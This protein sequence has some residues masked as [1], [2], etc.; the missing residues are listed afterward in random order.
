MS[1]RRVPVP[2]GRGFCGGEAVPPA[3]QPLPGVQPHPEAR[4]GRAGPSQQLGVGAASPALICLILGWQLMVPFKPEQHWGG[5]LK[6]RFR[7][8]W[9]RSEK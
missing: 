2:E 4:R 5:Y 6:M 8:K 7:E 3:S 1:E 9:V